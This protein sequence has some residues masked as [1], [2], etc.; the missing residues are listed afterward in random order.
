MF[1]LISCQ[2]EEER[3]SDELKSR[4]STLF[5]YQIVQQKLLPSPDCQKLI[6]EVQGEAR[7][8]L[9]LRSL[10]RA[11]I[12]SS[13]DLPSTLNEEGLNRIKRQYL[14]ELRTH[15]IREQCLQV[16]ND[17]CDKYQFRDPDPQDEVKLQEK[18]EKEYAFI[19]KRGERVR[20]K[21]QIEKCPEISYKLSYL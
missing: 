1:S 14:S 11:F 20:N 8:D 2:Q 4:L 15:G 9:R 12:S 13:F 7:E 19:I 3:E 5:T 18:I 17:E 6:Y 10:H 21:I 16:K